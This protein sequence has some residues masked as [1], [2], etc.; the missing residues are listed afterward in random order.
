MRA[1][2]GESGAPKARAIDWEE[3]CVDNCTSRP[4]GKFHEDTMGRGELIARTSIE[5]VV[6]V[7]A[8]PVIGD[9]YC[10]SRGGWLVGSQHQL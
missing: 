6:A 7:P 1:G 10:G 8:V 4:S 3:G 2:C 5:Q 9:T